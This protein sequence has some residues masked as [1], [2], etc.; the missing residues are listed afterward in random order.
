[1]GNGMKF[2]STILF[3]SQ[4]VL[5]QVPPPAPAPAPPPAPTP[6]QKAAAAAAGEANG[7]A[8][9]NGISTSTQAGLTTQTTAYNSLLN[10]SV[11]S[12]QNSQQGQAGA[13]MMSGS[14]ATASQS[15]V[16]TCDPNTLAGIEACSTGSVLAG[17]SGEMQT[18]T[19]TFQDP[20][21]KAWHNVC[22]YSSLGCGSP[23]VPNPYDPIVKENPP[24]DP[25]QYHDLLQ[26]YADKGYNVDPRTGI[27][28]KRDG[29][30]I[31]PNSKPSL[32]EGLGD[33]YNSLQKLLDNMQKDIAAKLSR[34]KQNS[35]WA[36][37]GLDS[38]KDLSKKVVQTVVKATDF[39][40]AKE[41]RNSR[42]PHYNRLP[43]K[44]KEKIDIAELIKNY[45]GTPIG[46]SAANIFK[47]VKKRYEIK[48]S[49]KVFLQPELQSLVQSRLESR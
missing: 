45:N 1:M 6:E 10:S 32:R 19:G 29:T 49:Q 9:G 34:I 14:L 25:G 3:L 42:R 5:A 31:N 30:T 27:V 37:L 12:M 36:A 28:T 40:G 8:I 41:D 18:S 38:L 39:A 24:P 33:S 15:Y 26:E 21:D 47:M 17:M 20:I 2:I 7:T 16:G 43:E 46:V 22:Q 23:F 48:A 11:D 4:I 35:Y 44:Q 13:M